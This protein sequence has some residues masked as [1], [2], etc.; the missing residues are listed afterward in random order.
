MKWI[1]EEKIKRK[2]KQWQKTGVVNNI[3]KYV[4]IV[5]TLL[6]LIFSFSK[7]IVAAP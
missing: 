3:G 5:F 1:V 2:H 7:Q 6:S 4:K